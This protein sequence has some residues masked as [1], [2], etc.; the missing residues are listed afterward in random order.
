[1]ANSIRCTSCGENQRSDLPLTEA[2][3]NGHSLHAQCIFD[4]MQM[5][6][7]HCPSC[8][9]TPFLDTHFVTFYNTIPDNTERGRINFMQI[10]R[11]MEAAHNARFERVQELVTQGESLGIV[12]LWDGVLLRA[13]KIA[14]LVATNT[15]LKCHTYEAFDRGM[16][17]TAQGTQA[18]ASNVNNL[19]I[20]RSILRIG[21]VRES[22]VRQRYETAKTRGEDGIVRF[23]EENYLSAITAVEVETVIEVSSISP[24]KSF[25]FTKR[26]S[27]SPGEASASPRKEKPVLERK[28]SSEAV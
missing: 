5:G 25:S 23:L 12:N 6:N 18:P 8:E 22:I 27:F 3:L 14:D 15:L 4:A 20:L 10:D 26:V 7:G 28:S 19:E 13:V 24:R 9:E 17:I 16:M 11:I 1:M 2:C 21:K